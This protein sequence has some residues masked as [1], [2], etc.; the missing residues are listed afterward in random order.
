MDER[1]IDKERESQMA[2]LDH[3]LMGEGR[4][5]KNKS[6]AP[7]HDCRLQA[8]REAL[9]ALVTEREGMLAENQCRLLYGNS[10]AYGD[11]HF[12]DLAARM[13]ALGEG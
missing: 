13:R 7:C 2:E 8:R 9:E 11:G 3:Y 10:P 12:N 6:L 1:D 4:E 5:L